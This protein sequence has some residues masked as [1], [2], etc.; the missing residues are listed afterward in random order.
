MPIRRT[1]QRRHSGGNE[2]AFGKSHKNPEKF[3]NHITALGGVLCRIIQ[4][5][6]KKSRN[7][8]TDLGGVLCQIIQ[9]T[10]KNLSITEHSFN[11]N[12]IVVMS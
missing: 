6:P 8:I 12:I 1:F 9:N 4:N 10:P 3:E 11:I 2:P 7:H 5:T